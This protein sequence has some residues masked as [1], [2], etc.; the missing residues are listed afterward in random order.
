MVMIRGPRGVEAFVCWV[1][2]SKRAK[3]NG[4]GNRAQRTNGLPVGSKQFSSDRH[5]AK[6]GS[7]VAVSAIDIVR[8]ELSCA[9]YSIAARMTPPN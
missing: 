4:V 1:I 7:R 9:I 6:L 8:S 2:G 5:A 3:R